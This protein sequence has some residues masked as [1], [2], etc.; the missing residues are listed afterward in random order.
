MTTLCE[1]CSE[2]S[3]DSSCR[4]GLSA[5]RAMSCREFAPGIDEFFANTADFT[6]PAQVLQM[7]TFFGLRGTEMKKVRVMAASEETRRIARALPTLQAVP[8]RD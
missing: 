1:F 3:A 2:R 6:G 5:P 8:R 4:R 7:A